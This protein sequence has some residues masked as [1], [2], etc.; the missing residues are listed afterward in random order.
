MRYVVWVI[1]VLSFPIS[2]PVSKALD[3]MLGAD[4]HTYYRRSELKH[5]VVAHAQPEAREHNP[6]ALTEQET[7]FISGAIDFKDKTVADAMRPL[8][9][10]ISIDIDR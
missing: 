8:E 3:C 7:H 4:H 6:A 5:F 9:K 10:V 1:I 2:W